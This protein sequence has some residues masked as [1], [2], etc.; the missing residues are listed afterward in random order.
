LLR[1]V[2]HKISRPCLLV[3]TNNK[4]LNQHFMQQIHGCVYA[5]CLQLWDAG[6]VSPYLAHLLDSKQMDVAGKRVLVPGCG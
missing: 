5:I 4:R 1:I 2:Q 3:A 6:K